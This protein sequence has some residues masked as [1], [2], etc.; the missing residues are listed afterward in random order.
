MSAVARLEALGLEIPAV[1]P[2]VGRYAATAVVGELLFVAGHTARTAAGP[3]LAGRVGVEV[4]MEQAAAEAARA[5]LNLLAAAH[6]TVG[7][8]R[9]VAVVQLRGYVRSDTDFTQHPS[10]IDG[11]SE[12]LAKV[13]P[14]AAP[15]TRAAIGVSSLPGGACVELEAVLRIG[16]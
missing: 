9:V 14:D 15:H 12:L 8:D 7:L 16:S 1:L 4:S 2:S 6:A 3:G 11:A 13:F 10:V 5:A